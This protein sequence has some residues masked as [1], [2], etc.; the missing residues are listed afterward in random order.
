MSGNYH[1]CLLDFAKKD[2]GTATLAQNV[3]GGGE[4]ITV[5]FVHDA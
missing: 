3:V 1:L 4:E 5:L 2:D